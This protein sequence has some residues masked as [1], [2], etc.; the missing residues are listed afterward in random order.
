MK[1]I[2]RFSFVAL[3][4][5]IGMNV[6]AA[7]VTDEL[8]W[9][10]LLESGKGSTYQEFSEKTI[11]SNAVYAGIASSGA[12]N[13]I[14]LR[15]KNSNE[16][17]VTTTSGGK[18]K[19]VTIAFN[20]KTTDRS[21]EIYGSNTAYTAATDLFG[22]KAGTKLGAIAG[23]DES[24]TIT[25]EG[26]YT[27]VGLRSSDGA[28][29]VNQIT[30]VWDGEGAAPETKTATTI[31]F[32]E[33]YQTKIAQG[34]DDM[35]PEV[36]SSV[37]LPTATVMAGDAAVA[38]ANV[39]WSLEV[40][41][42]KGK[43][44]GEQP[45]IANGKVSFDGYGELN[46]KASYAGNDTY[47]ASNKSY[48]LKVYNTYGKLS[49]MVKDIDDPNSEKDDEND[50]DG[51]L[52]F[53]FFRNIDAEGFPVLTNTVT[54]VNG[55]YIY[56]TDGEGNNLLFYGE[57]TQNLKQGDK[58]SGNVSDTNLGG[59]WGNLKRYNK[60]SE[61][62]FTEMN[63]K[64][65]SEGNAV[66]PT[67]ITVDKLGENMNNYV[68]IE[69]AQFVS[70][71]KKNLVF[72][73]GETEFTVYNQFSVNTDALEVGATY[74]LTGMGCIYKTT[75]Q[76]Y[77]IDFVKTAESNIKSISANRF[78]GAVYNLKGQRVQTMTRGLYIRDGKKIIVK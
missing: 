75:K 61:F 54:Y 8:T 20:E 43:K 21:I 50:K 35:F 60:L 62:A 15:T 51:K 57:N 5:M 31:E 37:A 1:K 53:Y 56:L 17:I 55:K 28:I 32:A 10:K 36:G 70:V 77:L 26:D 27:F 65:E 23:T 11:T 2:L 64:V 67:V 33:G 49:E 39:E 16:G 6:S 7:D 63:V 13:Y 3:M 42:W 72:K 66:E 46:L 74:T 12:D 59:F 71:D 19:S 69:N 24:K 73:V 40:K 25:V 58:I 18:L 78:N 30:I 38:G 48:T 52:T 14:Q 34:P 9:E 4:A 22:D 41:S 68:K 47:Q 29:Y 44:E 45:T 76:L